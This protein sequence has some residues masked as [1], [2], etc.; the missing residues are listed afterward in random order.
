MRAATPMPTVKPPAAATPTTIQWLNCSAVRVRMQ[1]SEGGIPSGVGSRG[2]VASTHGLA[3]WGIRPAGMGSA[4][5][6]SRLGLRTQ[7]GCAAVTCVQWQVMRLGAAAGA[8]AGR[9]GGAGE[10]MSGEWED[11]DST[12]DQKEHNGGGGGTGGDGGGTDGDGGGTGEGARGS[13]GGGS[14]GGGDGGGGGGDGGGDAI[15]GDSQ[16]IRPTRLGI[17]MRIRSIFG[18]AAGSSPS[19]ATPPLVPF[20]E[21]LLAAPEASA[22]GSAGMELRWVGEIR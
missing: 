18:N 5:G 10:Q 8:A 22:L 19:V 12:P 21:V 17:A 14:G 3:P 13:G 7:Q 15:S 1:P 16:I 2:I 11:V 20:S 9:A 4:D 6:L